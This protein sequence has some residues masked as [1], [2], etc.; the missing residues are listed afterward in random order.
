[1][2]C[3]RNKKKCKSCLIYLCTNKNFICSGLVKKGTKYPG[4]IIWLCLNGQ[5]SQSFLEMTP[6]EASYIISV[7]SSSLSKSLPSIKEKIE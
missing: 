7:L 2:K 3:P 5:L 1:M 4:D 6:K